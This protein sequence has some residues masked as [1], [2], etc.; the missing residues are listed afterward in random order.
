MV[1]LRPFSKSFEKHARNGMA[2]LLIMLAP[3]GEALFQLSQ[4]IAMFNP[5]LLAQYADAQELPVNLIEPMHLSCKGGSGAIVTALLLQDWSESLGDFKNAVLTRIPDMQD[6]PV[7]SVP[8]D[9]AMFAALM[10][11][12]PADI[13]IH[14]AKGGEYSNLLVVTLR[15]CNEAITILINGNQPPLLSALL[16]WSELGYIPVVARHDG[17]HGLVR[18]NF[19]RDVDDFFACCMRHQGAFN[20]SQL[21]N[22]LRL[23]EELDSRAPVAPSQITVV[24]D[25]QSW[26]R[27]QTTTVMHLA[28]TK[29][30]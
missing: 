3:F 4:E 30:A 27:T 13:D 19:E 17:L 18:L 14:C 10:K 16:K 29:P 9:N 22:A 7:L 15:K 1:W 24:S 26:Y 6:T 21:V 12:C 20:P 2:W 28:S 5:Y 8:V 11:D 23:A 25:I